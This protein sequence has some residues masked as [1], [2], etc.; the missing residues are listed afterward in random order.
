MVGDAYRSRTAA[1]RTSVNHS[2]P[3]IKTTDAL[4]NTEENGGEAIDNPFRYNGQ[5]TD[6]ETGLIYLRNRYYDPEIGRFTQEDPAKDGLNW[7][8]YCGNNP[9]AF[10]DPSGLTAVIKDKITLHRLNEMCK[11]IFNDVNFE[12]NPIEDDGSYKIDSSCWNFDDI[13][14][15]S[16]TAIA[17][18]KIMISNENEVVL[19]FDGSGGRNASNGSKS[20]VEVN[21][22][23]LYKTEENVAV[24]IH[25][26]THSYVQLMGYEGQLYIGAS[27]IAKWDENIVDDVIRKYQ[28]AAAMTV[29]ERVREELGI[30]SRSEVV[31]PEYMF[32][33]DNY[34][35]FPDEYIG[36]IQGYYDDNNK[37][38]LFQCG[39]KALS[40]RQTYLIDADIRLRA[41]EY[42]VK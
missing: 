9:I 41:G 32:G 31:G 6:E 26:L 2:P 18:L 1:N 25:E 33:V 13:T 35:V 14:G 39:G 38:S 23:N 3:K 16:E 4:G 7:Y 15:G 17:L 20:R 37:P 8:A 24:F 11:I 22:Y 5:Y 30:I 40:L 34:G 36:V 29:E 27:I 21:E 42:D 28:E 12:F 19:N 10:V